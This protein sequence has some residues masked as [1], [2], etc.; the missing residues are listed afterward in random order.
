MALLGI[1]FRNVLRYSW[2]IRSSTSHQS[3]AGGCSEGASVPVTPAL[4]PVASSRVLTSSPSSFW[5]NIAGVTSRQILSMRHVTRP[6]GH[7]QSSSGAGQEVCLKRR[8]PNSRIYYFMN[9]M[10]HRFFLTSDGFQGL[11]I[12]STSLNNPRKCAQPDL[13]VP[14]CCVL[15]RGVSVVVLQSSRAVVVYKYLIC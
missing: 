7:V 8:L 12:P 2:Y 1:L 3:S 10:L 15:R 14:P 6:P 4:G 13:W 11:C 9:F 5:T